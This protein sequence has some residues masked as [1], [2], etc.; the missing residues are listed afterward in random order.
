MADCGVRTGRW[1]KGLCFMPQRLSAPIR[2][3]TRKELG[4]G[5]P[6]ARVLAEDLRSQNDGGTS[7]GCVECF[8]QLIPYG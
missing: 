7:R 6:R 1:V 3:N 4:I 2:Y 8:L 5:T